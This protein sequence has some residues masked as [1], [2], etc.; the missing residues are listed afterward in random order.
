MSSKRKR[1]PLTLEQKESQ[2]IYL[3]KYYKKI[4]QEY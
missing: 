3:Q 1:K 4:E 2:K